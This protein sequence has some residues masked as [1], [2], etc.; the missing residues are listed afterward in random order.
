MDTKRFWSNE[1]EM[2]ILGGLISYPK[3]ISSIENLEIEYFYNN[4]HKLLMECLLNGHRHASDA[5]TMIDY[6][7]GSPSS[8]EF[9]G[10]DYLYELVDCGCSFGLIQDYANRIFENY[11][12]RK[13]VQ[14]LQ[15]TIRV[16][17]EENKL[18]LID[19][20]E[21]SQ[22]SLM[23]GH[24]IESE[25]LE[26]LS[27]FSGKMLEEF[28]EN[29][30]KPKIKTGYFGLD[31]TLRGFSGGQLIILAALTSVGK[32]T[33]A[34]NIAL[35]MAKDH[36][37]AFFSV[38]I[39]KNQIGVK[40]LSNLTRI[41]SGK[42]Q[43]CTFNCDEFEEISNK[44]S[45]HQAKNLFVMSSSAMTT[46]KIRSFIRG[47]IIAHNKTPV[48]FVDYLQLLK[49]G[50]S[51]EQR[52]LQI[53]DLAINLK[54]IAIEFDTPVIALCQLNRESEKRADKTPVL[55]DLRE[56]ASIEHTADVVLL[57]HRQN[58]EAGL[59]NV[60]IAKNRNGGKGEC[61]LKLRGEYSLFDEVY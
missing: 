36:H 2:G 9:G 32:T 42:I 25:K 24:S 35:N 49:S 14:N 21:L 59:T 17:N 4:K 6:A 51:K 19:M 23:V 48:V 44:S 53:A 15:D 12:K 16:F 11:K 22:K 29:N 18:T 50:L 38:E 54:S 34:L 1:I 8:K 10:E 58:E 5:L 41:H 43:D 57:A 40:I 33:M 60:I 37:I 45:C 20:I 61:M 52:H 30:K 39:S 7:N 47:H 55:S 28:G 26:S 46:Q 31:K 13:L 3:L 56:S 27:D